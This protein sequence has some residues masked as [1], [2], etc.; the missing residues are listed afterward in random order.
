MEIIWVSVIIILRFFTCKVVHL[1]ATHMM[2]K[3]IFVLPTFDLILTWFWHDFDK[4]HHFLFFFVLLK[5]WTF[6]IQKCFSF[7]LVF[8][9]FFSLSIIFRNVFPKTIAF[10]SLLEKK[11]ESAQITN[12]SWKPIPRRVPTCVKF[13]N[14]SMFYCQVNHEIL[15]DPMSTS[16]SVGTVLI[17][18]HQCS[19]RM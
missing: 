10:L 17:G 14:Y 12:G 5:F 16:M 13:L 15:C 8:T 4:L 6:T 3:F 18:T 1:M 2:Q 11:Q 7:N 19:E 9:L